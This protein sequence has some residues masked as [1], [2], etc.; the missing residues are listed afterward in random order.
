MNITPLANEITALLAP[1]VPYL[2]QAGEAA[3]GEPAKHLGAGVWDQIRALWERLLPGLDANGRAREALEVLEGDPG[4]ADLQAQFR[5]QLKKILKSD[6][7]LA[8]ALAGMLLDPARGNSYCARQEGGGALAQGSS[9]VAGGEVGVGGDVNGPVSVTHTHIHADPLMAEALWWEIARHKPAP[10]L[11]AAT[12]R[13]LANLVDRYR[14]LDFRGMGI[15]DRV[16]L[17][18]PLLHMYVPLKARRELPEGETWARELKVAGRAA[19]GPEREAMG[20][21]LSEPL[22]LIGL[23]R[24][25]PGLI[26]LGDPGAGKTTFLK[27]LALVLA[28]GQGAAMGLEPRLPVLLP[29]SA[30]ANA[31]EEQDIP[32]DRFI[33]RYH[34]E[35]GLDLPIDAML[36]QALA[37]GGALL[38][39]D[40]LDEVQ[41][42]GRR[43]LVVQRVVDFF[44]FHLKAGNKFVITSRLVGYPEV[45]PRVEGLAECTWWTWTTR[46]S[47]HSSISGPAPS[48]RRCAAPPRW[49]RSRRSGNAASCRTRCAT[50]PGCAPWRPTPCC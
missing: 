45:R 21:R 33:G 38:L 4:D 40:G 10:D 39:L 24:D 9:A 20:E 27:L 25:N 12:D 37:R 18:L 49:P 31:L 14:Y 16:A 47:R 11:A 22:P 32:L 7:E 43:H 35:R 13:Y 36:E 15:T 26:V 41:D 29:L 8:D 5:V 42:L 50:I 46:R 48:S 28:T 30:Y 19:S 3:A 23:L 6:A 2:K 1:A 17:K 44:S 34:R